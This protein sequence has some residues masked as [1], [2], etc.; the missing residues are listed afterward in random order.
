MTF[1][2]H[3]ELFVSLIL[4][5]G[6]SAMA[7]LCPTCGK[8]FGT[9]AKLHSHNEMHSEKVLTCKTCDK[10]I[11]GTKNFSN[12]IKIHMT[13]ECTICEETVKL[14]SKSAHMKI[15]SNVESKK[16]N[17]TECVDHPHFLH[18]VKWFDKNTL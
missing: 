2:N 5:F 14:N 13:Y 7:F 15:C 1:E 12:H 10:T 3:I 17:C 4:T 18:L 11:V 8:N 9:K 6:K 16:F